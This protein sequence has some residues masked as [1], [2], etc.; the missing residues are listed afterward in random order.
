MKRYQ[1]FRYLFLA[2]AVIVLVWSVLEAGR[3]TGR[4]LS[5]LVEANWNLYL[6]GNSPPV[7][8]F[9]LCLGDNA[10]GDAFVKV[11]LQEYP[12]ILP[13]VA[14]VFIWAGAVF[15]VLAH[16]KVK[17]KSPGGADWA[18]AKDLKLYLKGEKNSPQRGYYGI[19]RNGQVLRVP[20]RLRCA[21]TLVLGATGGGKSTRYYKPNMLMDAQDGISAIIIDLKYPDTQSGF[22]D[23]VP[24]FA[25]AGHDVQLFLPYGKH[26]L[27]FPLLADTDT[28]EGASEVANMLAP[29]TGQA[30]VDF[31]R[32]EERRL[33]T[34][35]LMG[36]ARDNTSSLGKLYRLLQKGRSA[37]QAY[38]H[39]HPDSQIREE[40]SG[41]FDFNLSTQ[42]N[43]IGGLAGKLQAFADERLDKATTA[44]SNPKENIDLESIGLGPTLLY[45]GIPQVHLRGAHGKLLLQLIK[46]AI[47]AALLKTADRHGGQLPNHVSFYLDEFTNLGV[48]PHI[49]EDLATMRSRR[50]AYHI[51]LQ[52]RAKGEALYGQAEFKAMFTNN[53]QQVLYF[54]RS[55][56][57]E[58]AEYLSKIAGMRKVVDKMQGTSREGLF[59]TQRKSEQLRYTAEP[60]LPIEQMMT[61]PE[62]EGVLMVSGAPPVRVRLPRVDEANVLGI[63]NPLYRRYKRHLTPLSPQLL[64]EILILQRAKEGSEQLADTSSVIKDR[65]LPP[66]AS[67][68][69]DTLTCHSDEVIGVEGKVGKPAQ[70]EAAEEDVPTPQQRFLKWLDEV[71]THPISVKLHSNPKTKQLSK[72]SLLGEPSSLKNEG[73]LELWSQK[74]WIKVSSQEIGLVGES[75]R[76]LGK[77][78]LEKLKALSIK[79]SVMKKPSKSLVSKADADKLRRHLQTNGRFLKGHPLREEA[80]QTD[81]PEAVGIYQPFTVLLE[82][83]LVEELLSMPVP[84]RLQVRKDASKNEAHWLVEL[85]LHEL[86]A[87]PKLKSW[88]DVNGHRLEGHPA[89]DA[90]VSPSEASGVILPE[91]VSLPKQVITDLLGHVPKTGKSTRPSLEGKRPYLIA[92]ELPFET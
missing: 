61:W 42:G 47:D 16:K 38:V 32:A 63:R 30:D 62:A 86:E 2:F 12:L 19:Y 82:K 79:A 25:V 56:R 3:A 1:F 15:S 70:S 7:V 51:S 90:S 58:D 41:F 87:F 50:V 18:K 31:Y 67:E 28:F 66:S 73:E 76:L 74:G 46:R 57:N 5:R 78:R 81:C 29:D 89:H 40:L 72:V 6:G 20:E 59:S 60:L 8:F 26:S 10:C 84:D 88:C 52:S 37:V 24:H 11:W 75:F 4:T 53:F 27:R 33:V 68:D 13:L 83:S 43:L 69:T 77:K 80:E 39:K 22:F 45:I 91:T 85:S 65:G 54:P 71:I 23:I 44:S 55:L 48:L 9:F 17:E 92:L 35:L 64:A 36:L 21:H 14:F 49:A 34:G